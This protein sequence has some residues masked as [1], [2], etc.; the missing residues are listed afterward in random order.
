[1]S[2]KRATIKVKYQSFHTDDVSGVEYFCTA[3]NDDVDIVSAMKTCVVCV[4]HIESDSVLVHLVIMLIYER[5]T[6]YLQ[7]G[8]KTNDRNV[9][10]SICGCVPVVLIVKKK[11]NIV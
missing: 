6:K 1:M 2:F 7:L 11:K 9:Y 5:S 3:E 4:L 10:F 8:V